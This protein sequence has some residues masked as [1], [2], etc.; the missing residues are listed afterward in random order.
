[1]R[2]FRRL[3][4]GTAPEAYREFQNEIHAAAF[5]LLQPCKD[6]GRE[7]LANI[8]GKFVAD[9]HNELTLIAAGVKGRPERG[10]EQKDF[11]TKIAVAGLLISA[12]IKMVQDPNTQWDDTTMFY[13]QL[14]NHFE[15]IDAAAETAL[16]REL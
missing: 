14:K 10:D 4:P 16:V 7:H 3:R 11:S 6:C 13:Y 12:L 5:N 1:M 9:Q 2:E 8:I 15:N